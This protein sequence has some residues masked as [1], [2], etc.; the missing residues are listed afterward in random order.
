M[1]ISSMSSKFLDAKFCLVSSLKENLQPHLLIN[2]ASYQIRN[3]LIT[4]QYDLREQSFSN[5]L[6]D[7]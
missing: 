5:K 3:I 2:K 4:K 6:T 7:F 1:K